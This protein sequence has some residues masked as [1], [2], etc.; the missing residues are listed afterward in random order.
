MEKYHF[1]SKQR[2]STSLVTE[3]GKQNTTRVWN[4]ERILNKQGRSSVLDATEIVY[5]VQA[6]KRAYRTK[7]ERVSRGRVS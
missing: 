3:K 6:L 5:E 7:T 2:K 4:Y 1:G